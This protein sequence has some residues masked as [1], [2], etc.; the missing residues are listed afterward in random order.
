MPDGEPSGQPKRS[1]LLS[2]NLSGVIEAKCGEIFAPQVRS[3]TIRRGTPPGA[4]RSIRE[5][6]TTVMLFQ[7]FYLLNC[8]WLKDS[9]FTIGLW[10]NPW[11]HVGIAV[12]LLLQVGFIYLPFMNG[13][14]G[15]APLRLASWLDAAAVAFVVM[16]LMGVETWCRK[17][18]AR[19]A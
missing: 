8:R 18:H 10:S 13:V 7:V 6:V 5:A 1:R 11:I 3:I 19:A 14:F 15:S 12:P 17:R 9:L 2:I 16:P 4:T